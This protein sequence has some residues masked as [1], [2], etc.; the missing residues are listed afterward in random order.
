[1]PGYRG[2]DTDW[3]FQWDGVTLVARMNGESG[4]AL[5]EYRFQ[6]YEGVAPWNGRAYCVGGQPIA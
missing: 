5:Q 1:M 4:Q 3:Q 6:L 2:E